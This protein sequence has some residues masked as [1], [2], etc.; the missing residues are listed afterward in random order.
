MKQHTN[1]RVIFLVLGLIF[2]GNIFAQSPGSKMVNITSFQ[3]YA[4][5]DKLNASWTTDGKVET[6]IFELQESSDGLEFKTIALI[7]GPDPRLDGSHY[8]C[9]IKFAGLHA[10]QS[11][12]YR[13]KHIDAEGSEQNGNALPLQ[14]ITSTETA[15]K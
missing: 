1:I 6:N 3:V 14:K 2:C 11:S 13:I 7:L 4:Q 9:K 5:N 8:S 12:L 10:G 15:S